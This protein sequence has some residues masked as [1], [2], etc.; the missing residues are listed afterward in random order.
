M[1]I[2]MYAEPYLDPEFS[3]PQQIYTLL[4]ILKDAYNEDAE[5]DEAYLAVDH[6]MDDDIIFGSDDPQAILDM[7]NGWN[8]SVL[9]NL[10]KAINGYIMAYDKEK[11]SKD[12]YAALNNTA[13]YELKK[14]AMAA[15]NDFY[16]FA[17]AAFYIPTGETRAAYFRTVLS[18]ADMAL[19]QS[20]PENFV[21]LE[22]AAK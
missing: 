12:A 19:I 11:A 3:R 14:A 9:E 5:D 4:R 8:L 17:E 6:V 15:D 22:V 2:L 21:I 20:E 10:R 16:T 18:N 1:R 7:A 13:T